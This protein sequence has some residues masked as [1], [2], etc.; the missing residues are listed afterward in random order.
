MYVSINSKT[1]VG[2]LK[3]VHL[4]IGANVYLGI[5]CNPTNLCTM[6]G[7]TARAILLNVWW[8]DPNLGR[9]SVGGQ[10]RSEFE[11]IKN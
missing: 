2:N 8:T 5:S 9:E 7:T 11:Q 1:R 10:T 4:H 6:Y 3:A